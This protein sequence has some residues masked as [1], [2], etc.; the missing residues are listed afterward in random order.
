[1]KAKQNDGNSGI[2]SNSSQQ[3]RLSRRCFLRFSFWVTGEKVR[4]KPGKVVAGRAKAETTCKPK[5]MGAEQKHYPS[6]IEENI[7]FK[8]EINL[9]FE[10]FLNKKITNLIITLKYY[11]LL[12]IFHKRNLILFS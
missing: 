6:L 2:K 12:K 5:Q 9:L 10:Y 4:G 7:L 1:M 8:V 3:Y 11:V